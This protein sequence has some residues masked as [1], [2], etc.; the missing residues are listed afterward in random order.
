MRTLFEDHGGLSRG[1]DLDDL[2]GITDLAVVDSVQGTYLFAATR[3]GGALTA[4]TLLADAGDSRRDTV[5]V[6]PDWTAQ[7]QSTDI[8]IRS[9][10][11]DG[12]DIVLAGLAGSDFPVYAANPAASGDVIT[13]LSADTAT[14]LNAAQVAEIAVSADG[15]MGLAALQG[16]GLVQLSYAVDGSASTRSVAA[17]SVGASETASDVLM[18]DLG[19]RSVAVASYGGADAVVLYWEN[20]N[21]Q[22]GARDLVD[23]ADGLW[24]DR[25][26]AMTAVNAADGTTYVVVASS[27][28]DSLSVM[29]LAPNGQ[30]FRVVDH[31]IDTLDTRFA[32]ASH[33]ASVDVGG[34]DYIV[35]AGTDSGLS[36]FVMLDGGRLQHVSSVPASAQSSLRG[37]TDIEVNATAD[38]A[39]LFVSTQTAPYLV[40]LSFTLE[41]PGLTL[42]APA[43]GGTVQGG[44]GDDL[45]TGGAGADALV[46]GAGDDILQ[47]GTGIDTLTGGA[48][49]D[50]FV[51]TSD[52]SRDIILDFDPSQDR[53]DLSGLGIVNGRG[54]VTVVSQSWGAELHVGT[55]VLEVRSANGGRLFASDFDDVTLITG[56]RPPVNPTVYDG[57][58]P[59]DPITDPTP[60]PDGGNTGGGNTGGN[61]GGGNTGGNTGGGNTGGGNTGGGD[62]GG[63]TPV[64]P[65]APRPTQLPGFAPAPPLRADEPEFEM[66]RPDSAMFGTAGSDEINA[67]GSNDVIFGDTGDDTIDSGDGRDSVSGDGGADLL[68][69]GSSNDLLLGGAGFDTLYG[70]GGNDTLAGGD[71]ADSLY[72][73]GGSDVLIGGNGF[74]QLYGQGGNDTMWAGSSPDRVFGGSGDDWISAGSNFGITVDGVWG[75]AGNDTLLGDAGYDLLDGGQGEDVL[76]GGD[77]ADNLYGQGGHDQLFG[78]RGLDRL[79]GGDGDD[80]LSGGDG[81]DGHFGDAGD[82]T[83]WGGDG[84]DRFFG[85]SGNDMLA[86]EGG[87][88]TINAGAGFD[89]IEGGAG[90]DMIWGRFNADRFLFR[91]GHGNDTIGDFTEGNAFEMI[92]FAH[93]DGINSLDDVRARTSQDG[94]DTLIT[95]GANSSIRLWDVDAS[96]LNADDFLF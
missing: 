19:G 46:G 22:L 80:L 86:G 2:I 89:T 87:N 66:T 91:P 84:D 41:N 48:G 58:A 74:D 92:D 33:V 15:T 73:G 53:I 23:A 4:Y 17:G 95:T 30:S 83:A 16:G 77:Q 8:A 9:T 96:A 34:R 36:L 52:A 81:P 18:L 28:S 63:S 47:D 12:F 40:E 51:I 94:N 55:Q 59:V 49:A 26:G 24:I 50:L 61:T 39:R 57:T 25:P 65:N 29:E 72:G 93:F 70:G 82:D 5:E 69:G 64:D 20:G 43:Q 14:G 13:G 71:F 7:L 21:G 32:D 45:L 6:L 85:G 44:A 60:D 11:G 67:N 62:T 31:V 42:A 54:S 27:G 88:D 56:G 35:A 10:G 1:T 38:G 75:E 79:F 3:G 90:D 78:G 37:I 76:Y 68:F